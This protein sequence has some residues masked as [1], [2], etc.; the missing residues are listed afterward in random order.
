MRQANPVAP[1][2]GDEEEE[3]SRRGGKEDE[4]EDEEDEE[5]EEEDDEPAEVPARARDSRGFHTDSHG[6]SQI[7]TDHTGSH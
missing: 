4:E 5:E 3:A 2:A 6:I 7:H 1:P